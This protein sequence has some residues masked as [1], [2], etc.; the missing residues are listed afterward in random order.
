[1]RTSIRQKIA[2]SLLLLTVGVTAGICIYYYHTA[3]REIERDSL[4]HIDTAF[5]M[6]LDDL[7]SRA[8]NSR[9]LVENFI[10]DSIAGNMRIIESVRERFEPAADEGNLSHWRHTQELISR[11]N[12]MAS[13]IGSFCKL[14]GSS[15]MSVYDQNG[16]LSV[17]FNQPDNAPPSLGAYLTEVEGGSFVS[18]KTSEEKFLS[19]K[20]LENTPKN[21]IPDSAVFLFDKEIP[22]TIEACLCQKKGELTIKFTAPVNHYGLVLGVCVIHIPITQEM[23][24]RYSRFSKTYI[25]MYCEETYYAGVLP[26][27][28]LAEPDRLVPNLIDLLNATSAPPYT[29]AIATDKEEE[30][31]YQGLINIG[32]HRTMG[33]ISVNYPKTREFRR[34]QSLLIK[35][36]SVGGALSL[37][38]LVA[39][40]LL[41]SA[42]V[43]PLKHLKRAAGEL[44][45]KNLSARVHVK[46][47][48]EVGL[49]ANTFNKMAEELQGNFQRIQKQITLTREEIDKRKSAEA[50]LEYRNIMLSTQQETSLDG[51]L[52]HNENGRIMVCNG[53]FAQLWHMDHPILNRQLNDPDILQH[54]VEQVQNPETFSS[55]VDVLWQNKTEN[56]RDEIILK[57]GRILDG[58]SSPMRNTKGE[59]LGR[60]WYF[61]DITEQRRAEEQLLQTQKMDVVGQLAGG[62]A[63]DFNNMLGGIMGAAQAI[64]MELDKNDPNYAFIQMIIQT[65][66]RAGQLTQKLLSFS[67]KGKQQVA[68]VDLNQTVRDIVD[69]IQHTFDPRIE[70]ETKLAE[71]SSTVSGDPVQ[72]HNALLNIALNA[73][74]AMPEG[75]RL[76]FATRRQHLDEHFASKKG[77]DVK[78]G[79]YIEVSISDTGIGM[80]EAVRKKLF[81][82]FYTTKEVGKG[83]GLGLSAVYGTVKDHKGAVSI[84]S[85]EGLGSIFKI[86][87]PAGKE[88]EGPPQA[89]SEEE[90]YRGSGTILLIDDEEVIRSTT[91][92]ML[93]H[94]GFDVITAVN[95]KEGVALYEQQRDSIVLVIIDF[96]MPKMNGPTAFRKI[97]KIN[98][99]A[100]VL[101]ASGFG[102]S[103]KPQQI[104]DEGAKAFIQKP[105]RMSALTTAIKQALS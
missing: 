2:G 96:V 12:R 44:S 22:A 74:D 31:Y 104:L 39:A 41:S 55:L 82:P 70:V 18:L 69:L 4:E 14:I 50:A 79:E 43:K 102:L 72:I 99:E 42:I 33:R 73:R 13:A 71:S 24:E 75:G 25:N 76:S 3:S 95:G 103:E 7:T 68:R 23:L 17:Y 93:H 59:Y 66:E 27:I 83:T 58:Y 11:Y 8:Q 91:S 46:T 90:L 67:R 20:G 9:P 80:S 84:Y 38:S 16:R 64:E 10:D 6:L 77:Q 28:H 78:P 48:D 53:P 1:M 100:R 97:R 40:L 101:L 30:E 94:I 52:V 98:P 62:I 61:R 65:S 5:A 56:S 32:K 85:E 60:V 35:V 19:L 88:E 51:I 36:A 81:E 29:V 37:M 26:E 47:R 15:D 86:Y 21:G 89:A 92:K 49:L 45:R 63:H 57:D 105:F 34:L 87:F 54:M